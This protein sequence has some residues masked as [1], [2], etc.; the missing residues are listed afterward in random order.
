MLPENIWDPSSD[1]APFWTTVEP[2]LSC[3]RLGIYFHPT[4]QCQ[5]VLSA[6]SLLQKP[7]LLAKL[8]SSFVFFRSKAA[9]SHEYPPSTPR[10]RALLPT[11]SSGLTWPAART[12]SSRLSGKTAL[13]SILTSPPKK[14]GVPM[15]PLDR[16]I[17]CLAHHSSCWAP[18]LHPDSTKLL[19]VHRAIFQSTPLLTKLG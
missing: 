17:T 5:R 1:F 19:F 12:S 13:M 8:L 11:S 15:R 7:I 10:T 18:H 16:Q 3:D 6:P 2:M 14:Q 9:H 4:N